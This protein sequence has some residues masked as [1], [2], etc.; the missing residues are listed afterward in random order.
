MDVFAHVLWTNAVFHVKYHKQRRLRYLAAFF[1]VLPDLIS[2]TP[3]F[4]YMILLG[5][6]ITPELL[7]ENK[8]GVFNYA[9]QSYQYTHSLVVFAVGLIIIT[10]VGNLYLYFKKGAMYRFWF[11]WPLLGYL[12]H[13]LIDIPSHKGLYE[14]PF[15][16][17]LSNVRFTHGLSWSDPTYMVVN[18]GSI[19]VIYAVMYYYQKL[20]NGKSRKS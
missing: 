20:K 6:V 11:F 9:L 3:V 18:Y 10:A 16:Y 2:F 14:T 15:L 1:G 5:K 13:I 8:S 7:M 12:L 17:P 19:V 4:L